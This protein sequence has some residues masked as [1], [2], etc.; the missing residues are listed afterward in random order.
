MN[1]RSFIQAAGGLAAA[2]PIK[3]ADASDN[4]KKK[5]PFKVLYSNDSTNI[6][7]CVS[8]YHK[9]TDPLTTEMIQATVDE[10]PGVDVHM[11]QPGLGWIPWWKSKVYPA[12][13]HYR[14]VKEQT[15]IGPDDFGKCVL[16][17]NDL[18]QVF[19]DRCRQRGQVPF[20]SYRLN[21]GHDRR[22]SGPKI[23]TPFRAVMVS[24]F[25]A[26]HPQ[27]RIGPDRMS[28]GSAGPQLGHSRSPRIQILPHS[29]D[30]REL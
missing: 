25:Y 5:A 17:G 8:P 19:V 13:E 28:C 14:W 29:R 2:L 18:L 22:T 1:R 26:E 24:R 23:R 12:A 3:A 10:V 15:G 11:L 4:R 30:L 6:I 21:D 7:T 16:A 9:R 27:Y 20:V